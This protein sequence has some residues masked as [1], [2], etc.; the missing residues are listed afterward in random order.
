MPIKKKAS[1]NR[2]FFLAII[3][4]LGGALFWSLIEFFTA[5]L[6][7][8]MFYVLSKHFV[9]WLI[10]HKKWKPNTTAV[11]VMAISFFII[12]V[13]IGIL[14]TMLYGKIINVAQNPAT[15]IKPIK[16]FGELIETRYHIN[17]INS[18]LSGIQDFATRFVSSVL[19]TSINFFTT[20]SMLY[21][22]LYFMIVNTNSMEAAIIQYLPFK[23]SHIE[24]FSTEL[25]AQTIGNA[26]VVPLIVLM[27]VLLAYVAYLIAGVGDPIFWGVITGFAS[28]IPIIGSALVWV[29]IGIYT[30]I[31]GHTWQGCFVIGWGVLVIGVSDNFMRLLLAKKIADVHPIVTILGVVLGLKYFGLTGLIFGPLIISYF[32][33]LIKIYRIEYQQSPTNEK[34]IE[35][36]LEPSTEKD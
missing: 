26:V 14:A 11:L 36:A 22:F 34:A 23:D 5:F 3:I 28:I 12:L 33:I 4:L 35:E 17:I 2:Y 30:I 24:L 27:H 10:L 7:A 16:D 25:K 13:P 20:I 6:A 15:L 29:P 31:S 1:V 32:L 8:T 18:S 19:N 9:N 21:F